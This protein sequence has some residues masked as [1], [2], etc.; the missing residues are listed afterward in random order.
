MRPIANALNR[1]S[2]AL[3]AWVT[4]TTSA[5]S[6]SKQLEKSWCHSFSIKYDNW[7]TSIDCNHSY[8]QKYL[9]LAVIESP[10]KND[11]QQKQPSKESV[12]DDHQ[13]S[14]AEKVGCVRPQNAR[15]MIL[16]TTRVLKTLFFESLLR[17]AT[18]RRCSTQ[19]VCDSSDMVTLY[20]C[21]VQQEFQ[22][23]GGWWFCP[24]RLFGLL[25]D[26]HSL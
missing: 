10:K 17:T 7:T 20:C 12:V 16:E 15:T 21:W 1:L 23:E 14:S 9:G 24:G 19:S 25:V 11:N 8:P 5:M 6:A 18:W 13:N 4:A 3:W 22:Y 26:T 2:L